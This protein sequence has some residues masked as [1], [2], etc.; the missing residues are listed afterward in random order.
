MSD[1]EKMKI[2]LLE[3]DRLFAETIED[4]LEEEGY[5][6][7]K[8]FDP[9]SAFEMT[10]ARKYDL[11]L[12]DINLPFQ[13]GLSVLGQLRESGDETPVI[14]ITSRED[15]NSMLEGFDIGADD[16]IRKPFDLDELGARIGAISRRAG[17]N[18]FI[19]IDEYVLDSGIRDITRDGKPMHL[20]R[21]IYD[22]LELLSSKMDRVVTMDEIR[23]CLWRSED[24]AS[25]GA[26]RVYVTRLKKYFPGRIE[27]IRGVGYRFRSDCGSK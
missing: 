23:E 21:K 12:F 16:Y 1:N 13:D 6:V 24:A 25:S 5:E 20:G 8:V 19:E 3:D 9:L 11:Y 2:L 26:V 15:K 27:N 7:E 10:Y 4:Y 17:R 14:F 18:R 22:L